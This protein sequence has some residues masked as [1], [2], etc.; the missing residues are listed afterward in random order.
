M[1]AVVKAF[2]GWFSI[3]C[4]AIALNSL[5][6]KAALKYSLKSRAMYSSLVF[7]QTP[8]K[9]PM[10]PPR[11]VTQIA[12]WLEFSAAAVGMAVENER[13][14]QLETDAKLAYW[15]QSIKQTH[16]QVVGMDHL[17]HSD[18]AKAEKFCVIYRVMRPHYN[19]DRRHDSQNVLSWSSYRIPW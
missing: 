16:L 15:T 13:K 6:N 8:S 3:I 19:N 17:Q 7:G 1:H 5:S 10:W 9:N 4:S 12:T 18:I 11:A 14:K 2:A